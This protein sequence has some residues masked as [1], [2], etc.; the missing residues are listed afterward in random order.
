MKVIKN[1]LAAK[2]LS[3]LQEVMLETTFPW[4]YNAG[5]S[6]EED[7]NFQF[8]HIFFW[9]DKILSPFWN[10]IAPI[11]DKLQ[12]KKI[13]RIK[14]NLTTKKND[15]FKSKMHIDTKI[16]KSKT[17]VFYCNTNNGATIFKD[18]NVVESKENKMVIFNSDKIHCGSDCTDKDI[19]IVINF[20]YFD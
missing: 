20:N 13:I 18:G 14:A 5:K 7:N 11:L 1:V 8:V 2:E 16:K 10:Y 12:A 17:A 9:E 19:R 6:S 15:N 3:K 4:Y